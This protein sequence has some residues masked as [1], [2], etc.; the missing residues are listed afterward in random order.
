MTYALTLASKCALT[1]SLKHSLT[2]ALSLLC[3]C[4]P[5][6]FPTQETAVRFE[7]YQVDVFNGAIHQPK[8]IR[9]VTND[10][11][12]DSLEN[13]YHRPRS[14]LPANT[15]FRFTVAAPAVVTTL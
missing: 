4:L 7:D 14:T 9:R 5:E 11:W 15:S 12:R 3:F 6:S 2:L 10:E 13:S 1:L 8:W